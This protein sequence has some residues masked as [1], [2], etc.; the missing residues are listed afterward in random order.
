MSSLAS[1][2][3][4]NKMTQVR[5]P[6]DAF[7]SPKTVA[8]IGATETDGSVGPTLLSN[9]TGSSF[10]GRI[11]PV[12]RKRATV[13]RA[14]PDIARAPERAWIWRSL[15]HRACT[16]PGIVRE[17]ADAG[18]KAAVIISG[19]FRETGRARLETVGQPHAISLS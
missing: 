9:L 17:C 1:A 11:F 4:S 2:L 19:G 18:V 16:V 14:Y 15:P 3:P 6:L 8:V 5:R 7:F 13:H 12:N 10:S